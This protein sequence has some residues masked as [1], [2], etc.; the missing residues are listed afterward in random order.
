MFESKI[1]SNELCKFTAKGFP[2]T[3]SNLRFEFFV[4][5]SIKFYS[6]LT[7]LKAKYNSISAGNF[8][9]PC[10]ASN[11]FL[12]KLSFLSLGIVANASKI[13]FGETKV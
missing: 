1:S 13:V 10:Q 6:S 4:T 9:I 8:N 11:L 7:R 2:V 12:D 3:T 5:A